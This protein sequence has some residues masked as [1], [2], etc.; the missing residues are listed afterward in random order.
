VLPPLVA[1]Q[2]L[3]QATF[4]ERYEAMPPGTWAEL[5]GG[6]VYLPSPLRF[7]RGGTDEVLGYWLTHYRR[8]T[9]GLQSGVNVT[10]KLGD[11]GEPQPDRQLRIPFE[12]GGQA[13][14]VDGYVTGPPELVAEVARSSRP[15]DLGRKKDD[16]VRAGVLEYLFVGLE[17]E[18]IR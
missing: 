3:D 15:F 13:R 2:R 7:E 6:I 18:E 8:F 5:V 16:Y 11:Y 12:R 4:H 9:P 14:V 10:T 1:G 17:P